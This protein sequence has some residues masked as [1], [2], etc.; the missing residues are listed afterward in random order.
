M[1]P[2]TFER[3]KRMLSPDFDANGAER[4]SQPLKALCVIENTQIRRETQETKNIDAI[5]IFDI[6]KLRSRNHKS[7]FSTSF[8]DK[9]LEHELSFTVNNP[10]KMAD[11][12]DGCIVGS[13][14]TLSAPPSLIT[15]QPPAKLR[16]MKG[17][18]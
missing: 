4:S 11:L 15:S 9:S 8:R 18:R 3:K 1:L 12:S 2:Q 16:I 10:V 7:I 14:V 17:L 5:K 6:S 13:G